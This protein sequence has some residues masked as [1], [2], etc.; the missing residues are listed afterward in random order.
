M[1]AWIDGKPVTL[2]A[3]TVEA[4]RVLSA[5][6]LPVIAGLGTDIAG[7]RAAVALARLTGGA[8]DHMH[9]A[10]LLRD[11]DVMREAGMM[12]TTPSEARLRGD[13]LFLVGEVFADGLQNMREHLLTRQTAPDGS[14]P[15]RI[16]WLCPPRKTPVTGDDVTIMAIGQDAAELPTLI[17]ALRA[18][19]AG[20]KVAIS[21]KP[22]ESLDAVAAQ[23]TAARFGVAVW[24]AASLDGLAIEMLCG[25]VGDLNAAT[26]FTGLP[27]P[28]A[29]N[30]RGALEACGWLTGY[31]M[32]TGF[33]RGGPE[34]DPWRFDA[35]RLIDS[36]EGDC[37]VWISAYRAE[38][39]A[40]TRDVPTIALMPA[41]TAF[42]SPPRVHIAV[43][44][45][46]RDHDTV[47]YRAQTCALMP[48]LA[49][50][51]S[52]TVSVAGVIADIAALLSGM[53][54]WPC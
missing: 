37:A 26:R 13:V 23:L 17:A 27:L 4:A 52:D 48:I 40:W 11:L 24:S 10:A 15:R 12:V 22:L 39:P 20:R 32:R 53:G 44:R 30:A 6:R 2:Q 54:D 5:G 36:G 9:S 46:G 41:D 35:A 29:D 49:T 42:P 33:A 18:R 16:V 50:Q 7:V 14:G 3:A 51:P 47:D 19:V 21:G 38:L 8:I 28:A 34:H 31:P 45:P 1:V 43:G 25:L